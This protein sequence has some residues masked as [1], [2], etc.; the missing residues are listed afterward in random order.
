[1]WALRILPGFAGI[2]R[3]KL[4]IW[5]RISE[6]I[7]TVGISDVAAMGLQDGYE[8]SSQELWGDRERNHRG[9]GNR[10][11]IEAQSSTAQG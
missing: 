7:E 2:C 4:L 5:F 10:L 3:I 1:M 8:D 9:L 6:G 11:I